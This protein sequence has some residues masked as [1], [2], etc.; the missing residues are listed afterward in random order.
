MSVKSY[1]TNYDTFCQWVL[2]TE[3]GV[4]KKILP[5]L[6]EDVGNE[7]HADGIPYK[8]RYFMKY[9]FSISFQ[10]LRAEDADDAHLGEEDDDDIYAS[11]WV[12]DMGADI[13]PD[14]I[15]PICIQ[16]HPHCTFT[17]FFADRLQNFFASSITK[18]DY[19][20]YG[21]CIVCTT[22][23]RDDCLFLTPVMKDDNWWGSSF[24]YTT[25]YD[26]E[27]NLQDIGMHG[28]PI[29]L[30]FHKDR[31][32]RGFV[33]QPSWIK[34]IEET[35]K[36]HA[37]DDDIIQHYMRKYNATKEDVIE[38]CMAVKLGDT[39]PHIDFSK[40][41]DP[42]MV[43]EYIAYRRYASSEGNIILE[44]RSIEYGSFVPTAFQN[45]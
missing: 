45:Y 4:L 26:M 31:L 38:N 44:H 10:A 6:L 32:V 13:K 35:K 17:E 41:D 40:E 7:L 3:K 16:D 23:D 2:M 21:D 24:C 14:T 29:I 34:S 11:K 1:F 5:K 15:L 28:N 27:Y 18:A 42:D 8:D 36:I 43:D 25:L 39:S 20:K 33:N 30:V 37:Y 12:E 9:P 19:E 22:Q